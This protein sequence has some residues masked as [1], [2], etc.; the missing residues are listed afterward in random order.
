MRKKLSLILLL[1]AFFNF[2]YAD[3]LDDI[4]RELDEIE[5]EFWT[6]TTLEKMGERHRNFS[7]KMALFTISCRKI[8]EKI[9]QKN[10]K[11]PNLTT[12]S[13][14]IQDILA[15]V[16]QKDILKYGILK[17]P[18]YTSVKYFLNGDE[19]PN[20]H[21][22]YSRKRYVTNTPQ[23]SKVDLYAYETW[24][25][26]VKQD[27]EEAFLR[28]RDRNKRARSKSRV[29]S[30]IDYYNLYMTNL[31]KLRYSI[32]VIRQKVKNIDEL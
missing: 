19:Q 12:T 11:L 2:L 16:R 25:N 13:V 6:I 8:Q 14:A 4:S 28:L 7:R 30:L 3:S 9:N 31:I 1:L 32:E 5:R 23:S 29:K 27:N 21:S 20:Y 17:Y 18:R 24:L 22:R 10:L 15:E 26:K